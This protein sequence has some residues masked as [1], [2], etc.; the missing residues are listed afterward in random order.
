MASSVRRGGI[1]TRAPSPA[2]IAR[3][4][5]ARVITASPTT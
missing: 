4:S 2:A 3:A 5:V 1:T